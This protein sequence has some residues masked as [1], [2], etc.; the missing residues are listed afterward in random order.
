MNNKYRCPHCESI[1]NNTLCYSYES[2]MHTFECNVCGETFT[3]KEGK[4]VDDEDE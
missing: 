3:S 2:D 1:D 4:Y